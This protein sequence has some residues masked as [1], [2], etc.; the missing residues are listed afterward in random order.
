MR[1]RRLG[2]IA[3]LVLAAGAPAGWVIS[4]RLESRNEFCTSCHLNAATPLHEQ[5]AADFA[6]SPASSLAAA[7]RAA[8]P[9]FRCIDC[10]GGASFANRLRV[11]SVAAR[12][13]LRYLLGRFEEPQSMQHPLWNEDCAKCH[14]AYSPARADAFH[15]IEVHNLPAFEFDCVQCHD[16]HPSGRKASLEYL[17]S[18]RLVAVCRNC[19]EEF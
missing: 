3:L 16:A 12:D 13:A 14:G 11:K 8:K 18:E 4:D 9:E 6:E 15:A 10:H 19:H 1:V 2:W 7:H 5:K 17:E